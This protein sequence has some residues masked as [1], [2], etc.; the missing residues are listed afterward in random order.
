[1]G[2]LRNQAK[3]ASHTLF[4]IAGALAFAA[5]TSAGTISGCSF[6]GTE[7]KGKVQVVSSFAD[8]KV[9]VVESFSDLHVKKV[10]SFASSGGEWEFV[11]SH[12]DFTIELV[13]SFPDV[14]V[15]YVS[16]FP[17]VT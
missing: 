5:P 13:T 17:G 1:M 6:N 15:K 16:S 4:F 2:K 3:R 10:G 12:P 9:E 14:K 7:L 8:I 11:D